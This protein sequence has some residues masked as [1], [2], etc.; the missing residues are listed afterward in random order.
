MK[1]QREEGEGERQAA[2][3]TEKR[4]RREASAAVVWEA[5]AAEFVLRLTGVRSQL[6][7]R[8]VDGA[9]WRPGPDG[10]W[11][12]PATSADGV[13]AVLQQWGMV[14]PPQLMQIAGSAAGKA[15]A[16]GDDLLAKL[17]GVARGS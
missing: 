3:G 2:K 10:G 13:R 17:S 1:R 8:D 5:P 15:P 16:L 6:R 9:R 11:T 12:F 7:L 4:T 14:A